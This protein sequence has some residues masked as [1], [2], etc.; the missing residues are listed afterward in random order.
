MTVLYI[1]YDGLLDPLGSSQILPYIK[2]ISKHKNEVVVVSFEKVER[3]AQGK[4]GLL[5]NI[6]DYPIEWKPLRFTR[7]LGV[8]GKFWDL[9]RMYAKVII[10]A[11]KYNIEVV[12]TRGHPPAQVGLFVKRITKAKFIFDFRG[13]WVNE[14]VDKGGWDLNFFF[15]RLQYRFFKRIERKCL[16][17]SDHVVVLTNK[18]VD[19][20]MKLGADKKSSITVIPCCADYDHFPLINKATKIDSRI[21]LGIPNDAFVLGYLGSAGKMYMLDKFFLLFVMTTKIRS[22]CHTLLIT[23]D[24]DRLTPI[25]DRYLT[26]DLLERVHI[27]SVKHDQ[28]PT[29]LP[30]IDVMVSLISPTY[31]RMGASPTKMAESFAS[32]IPVVANSGV[33]DV[34]EIIDHLDG[35]WIVDP[36]SKDGLM[37]TVENLDII[38][39]KGGRRLRDVSRPTLGL[40]F[41]TKSYQSVY[42][43]LM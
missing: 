5:L 37:E 15:H 26:H 2:G 17:Q 18:V 12:H 39:A 6:Q 11:Y 33:G 14:R 19:E 16:I 43:K 13:L 1:T 24:T 8:F 23:P 36:H 20:V 22:D 31:A 40:E 38:S 30:A 27:K 10:I 21:S 34:Q 25:M 7:G 35:G 4:D 32:G 9:C 3:L 41:A 29:L 42:E 28:V